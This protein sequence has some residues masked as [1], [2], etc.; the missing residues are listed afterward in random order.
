MG[1][2]LSSLVLLAGAVATLRAEAVLARH[3]AES[4]ADLAALAGAA[5][6]GVGGMPCMSAIAVA[7]ANDAAVRTCRVR[8]N[9]H[10][11]AGVV[12][13][14]VACTVRFPAI[15]ARTVTARARAARL[16]P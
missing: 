10:Q 1:T 11:R 9:P 2:A 8:L 4:S 14:T 6:I 5:R 15:G 12:L 3:R 16:P 13:V 7:H